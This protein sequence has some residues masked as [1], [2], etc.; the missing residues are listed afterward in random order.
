MERVYINPEALYNFA[1]YLEGMSE[2]FTNRRMTLID[3]YSELATSWKHDT[4]F[5]EIDRTF[6]HL[7]DIVMPFPEECNHSAQHLRD[8][9]VMVE[10]LL[11]E[12]YQD[13]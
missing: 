2:R 1:V 9:A 6:A 4:R 3:Q 13:Y 11:Q 7:M 5:P 8:L 10:E 12:D